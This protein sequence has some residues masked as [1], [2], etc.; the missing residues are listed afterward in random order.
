MNTIK[1]ILGIVWIALAIAVAYFSI[2]IFGGKLT[3]DK[4]EDLVFG[5]IIFFVLLPLIVSGLAIFGWYSIKN[6]YDE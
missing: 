6:E 2:G 5:I 4:Q 1:K 3:S